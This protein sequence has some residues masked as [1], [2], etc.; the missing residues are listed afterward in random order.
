MQ[1][2]AIQGNLRKTK[3]IKANLALWL[4]GGGNR[5]GGGVRAAAIDIEGV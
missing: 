1:S 3:D 2:K 5:S 4:G